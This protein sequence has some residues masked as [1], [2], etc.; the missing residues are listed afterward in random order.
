MRHPKVLLPLLITRGSK[1][2]L[3][4][5]V[6][7][8]QLCPSVKKWHLILG[9]QCH[10]CL[11][12]CVLCLLQVDEHDAHGSITVL[13]AAP[14]QDQVIM[15]PNTGCLWIKICS[16][17][18]TICHLQEAPGE[19]IP[20]RTVS[21]R[22]PVPGQRG[23][24]IRVLRET[25]DQSALSSKLSCFQLFS[26]NWEKVPPEITSRMSVHQ[27]FSSTAQAGRIRIRSK[28]YYALV[29]STF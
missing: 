1:H 11:C 10:S 22:G 23:F 18:S 6:Q 3:L 7:A 12:S 15:P 16:V 28:D 17:P 20:A 14:D 8:H 24:G 9:L 26:G 29:Q 27:P 25:V 4:P 19:L 5:L 13:K 21:Q 2:K